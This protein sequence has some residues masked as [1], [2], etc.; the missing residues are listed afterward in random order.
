MILITRNE[1]KIREFKIC[2]GNEFPF[3]AVNLE[4][5]ELR[6]EDP[7][8]IAMI[9]AKALAE[10]FNETV[11][12]EDSGIFIKALKGFPGTFTRYSDEKIGNKG[13]VKLMKGVKNRDCEYKSAIGYCAPGGKPL[14]FLGVEKGKIANRLRGNRGWGQDPIFIPKGKKKTYGE[15]R[16]EGDV[17]IFRK[18]AIDKLKRYLRKKAGLSSRNHR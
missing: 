15:I 8:E 17:N 16:K 9:A 11:I 4:Y 3:K 10:R 7:C 12:V 18:R 2:L 6:S 14:C 13:L 1:K 5:P